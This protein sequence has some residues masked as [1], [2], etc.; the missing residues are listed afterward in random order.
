MT[1]GW[2]VPLK[3]VTLNSVQ[4]VALV[5]DIVGVIVIVGIGEIDGAND[6]AVVPIVGGN[7][8][9]NEIEVGVIAGVDELQ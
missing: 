3:A 8:P 6:G 1:Q 2:W 5:G 4:L 9:S 7:V